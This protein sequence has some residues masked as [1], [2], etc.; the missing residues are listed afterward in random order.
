VRLEVISAD[1]LDIDPD[2]Q[3]GFTLNERRWRKMGAEWDSSKQG[4]LEVTPDASGLRFYVF[5]GRHRLIAG[6]DIAGVKEFRCNVHRP[7]LLP[8][9]RAQRKLGLDRD[10]RSVKTIE[11]FLASV[12]AED[13]EAVAI[14]NEVERIGFKVGKTAGSGVPRTIEAIAVLNY[15]YRAGTLTAALTINRLWLGEPKTTTATWLW[16]LH[17]FCSDGYHEK[18]SPVHRDRLQQMIPAIVWRRAIAESK[19]I[20]TTTAGTGG[21]I[22]RRI[23]DSLRRGA[24]IARKKSA[25]EA[26]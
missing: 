11:S 12:I 26:T 23:A 7:S 5:D 21:E 14:K 20:S 9:E 25:T 13:P 2:V 16:G 10:R 22:P 15:M 19:T 17:Y 4:V 8:R 1:L 3:F 6:R 18:L 24:R